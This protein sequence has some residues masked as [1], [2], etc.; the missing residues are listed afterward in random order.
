MKKDYREIEIK[1]KKELFKLEKFVEEICD[2][3]NI[4]NEYFG[5]I[6]LASTEAANILISLAIE[7]KIETLIISFEKSLKGFNFKIRIIGKG[8]E[9][10]NEF[11]LEQEVRKHR[12]SRE[13]YIIKALADEVT[14]SVT[15]E[16]IIMIFY[17]SSINYEKSLVRINQLK[18]YWVKKRTT[19]RKGNE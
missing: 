16:S 18:E 17:V 19:I 9:E 15:G 6:L 11:R 2:Y 5:N 4:N 8:I 12:L 10:G 14:I 13:I 3:H 7:N 1:G